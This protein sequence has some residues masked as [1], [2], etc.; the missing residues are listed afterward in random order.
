MAAKTGT[1]P[2]SAFEWMLSLRYLRARRKE[3]FISVIAGFSFLGI[4]L[5]VATLIIV[6]AV[7]NGFR[8]ELMSKILGIN[9]HILVQPLESAMTDYAE[10]A[11]RIS[12]IKGVTLAVPLVEGQALASSPFQ[13]GGVLVRGIREEDL[14]R[15]PAI[16]AGLK[17][18]SLENF[19]KGQGVL[20]GKRLAD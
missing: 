16:G 19:D 20:I 10:V 7:M 17:S 11:K 18:G 13:A 14:R 15:L 4:L 5:G 8:K 9:G 12:S 3:G 1:L 2:F 6:M